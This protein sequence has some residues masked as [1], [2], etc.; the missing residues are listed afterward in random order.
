MALL[1]TK[2]LSK[3]FGGLK[4]ISNLDF[5]LEE[6]EVRGLIGPNGSGKSTFFNLLTGIYKADIG[7]HIFLNGDEIT[8]QEPH[9]IVTKGMGR[10]FQL[11]RLFAE[12]TVIDN[13]MVG[14]H[15]HIK[16]SLS[17]A[18]FGSKNVKIE[19]KLVKDEMMDLLSYIGLVDYADIDAIELSIGQRRL[20][21]LGRAMA[22]RPRVL[23]LDEPAAGLSPVNVDNILKILMGLK[24]RYHTTLIIIEH[25]LKVVMDTCGIIT[26][27]DYG[28]KI[29]EGA[30]KEVK[31]DQNVVNAY[32]GKELDDEEVRLNF[33]S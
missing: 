9:Y 17:S 12:M 11:L 33:N 18:V 5:Q 22:M 30:P 8:N 2:N 15:Q 19:E 14:Y 23:L 7:S 27:L 25:I 10:T 20:L 21:S 13:L 31:I 29:S 28:E 6:G 1:E 3:S 26:V 32:L 24:D 16:Y 4:A